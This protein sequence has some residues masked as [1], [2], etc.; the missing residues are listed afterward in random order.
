[1]T[2]VSLSQCVGSEECEVRVTCGSVATGNDHYSLDFSC[3]L[4]TTTH[5]PPKTPK[6]NKLLISSKLDRFL[7]IFLDESIGKMVFLR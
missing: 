2:G 6:Y 3:H 7:R 5:R 1:M 4:D